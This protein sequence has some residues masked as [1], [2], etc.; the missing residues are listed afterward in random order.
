MLALAVILLPACGESNAT[1]TNTKKLSGVEIFQTNC[2]MCHGRYGNANI[3][4]AA[5]LK[6]SEIPMEE[7]V[8]IIKFGKGSMTA[9]GE[10]LNANEIEAVAQHVLSLRK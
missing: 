8:N 2:A 5:D 10:M 4:G 6:N 7:V 9:Y 3:S 1:P